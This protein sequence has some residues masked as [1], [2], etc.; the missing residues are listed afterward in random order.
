MESI[1]PM[2]PTEAPINR[3]YKKPEPYTLGCRQHCRL[4]DYVPFACIADFKRALAI[5]PEGT[6]AFIPS[7]LT[8]HLI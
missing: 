4:G 6:D 8:T 1:D 7:V 5:E 2:E 3:V